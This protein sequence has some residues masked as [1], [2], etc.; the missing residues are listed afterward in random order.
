M[1]VLPKSP[2]LHPQTPGSNRGLSP[3]TQAAARR[4]G[5]GSAAARSPGYPVPVQPGC[6]SLPE[7]L[8]L[9][10]HSGSSA[11]QPFLVRSYKSP[12]GKTPRCVKQFHPRLFI[13]RPHAAAAPVVDHPRDSRTLSWSSSR[14]HKTPNCFRRRER[15]QVGSGSPLISQPLPSA[16]RGFLE[17]QTQER[18]R[19]SWRFAAPDWLQPPAGTF[20]CPPPPPW[21]GRM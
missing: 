21:K 2:F 17:P 19:L 16:P 11:C 9:H 5:W 1:W 6:S 12:A 7:G 10:T 4:S 13:A 18:K 3:D 8:L 15:V 20:S 14:K